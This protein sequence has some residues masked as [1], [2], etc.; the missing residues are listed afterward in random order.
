M[1]AKAGKEKASKRR[2]DAKA[3]VRDMKWPI[4][5]DQLAIFGSEPRMILHT[6]E[7]KH[8]TTPKKLRGKPSSLRSEFLTWLKLSEEKKFYWFDGFWRDLCM[9]NVKFPLIMPELM[10]VLWWATR[11]DT[12]GASEHLR[13]LADYIDAIHAKK[14]DR[15]QRFLFTEMLCDYTRRVKAMEVPI[16]TWRELRDELWPDYQGSNQNFQKMLRERG[17]PFKEVGQFRVRKRVRSL[18]PFERPFP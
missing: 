3:D 1:K 8:F 15:G 18:D 2:A 7:E 14:G 4:F 11:Q 13:M 17:S 12:Q 16:L 5:L 10:R 9:G 6:D